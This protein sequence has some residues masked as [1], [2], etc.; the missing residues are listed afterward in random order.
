MSNALIINETSVDKG[1]KAFSPSNTAQRTG[2]KELVRPL[3]AKVLFSDESAPAELTVVEPWTFKVEKNR[4]YYIEFNL[5]VTM[6]AGIFTFAMLPDAFAADSSSNVKAFGMDGATPMVALATS[7]AS[8]YSVEFSAASDGLSLV[9]GSG[10][11]HALASGTVQMKVSSDTITSLQAGS[12]VTFYE[13]S[14]VSN[15]I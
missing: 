11:I 1:I 7:A 5:L 9:K 15:S 6:A 8:H 2:L 10:V 13:V 4:K 14:T 3:A 12:S